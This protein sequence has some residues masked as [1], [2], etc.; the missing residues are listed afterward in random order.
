[1]LWPAFSRQL[2]IR[3]SAEPADPATLARGFERR[4]PYLRQLAWQNS[5]ELAQADRA[6]RVAE[7]ARFRAEHDLE[8]IDAP[9]TWTGYVVRPDRLTFWW[10]DPE[11]PS[12]RVEYRLRSSGVWS[13]HHLPG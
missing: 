2:V 7:W 1:M 13:A 12:H 6:T 9:P 10:S 5:D 8:R 3:G 4:S 11:G